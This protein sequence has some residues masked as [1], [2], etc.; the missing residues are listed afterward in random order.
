MIFEKIVFHNIDEIYQHKYIEGVLLERIPESVALGLSR[1]GQ[2]MMICPSGSEIRFVSTSYPVR[3]TLSV[4]KIAEQLGEG[5]VTDAHIFFGVFHSRQRFVIKKR[6]TVLE[7]N[8]P[9]NFRKMAERVT[10]NEPFSYNVCRIRFWGTSMGAP[11]RFHNIESAGKIRPPAPRETPNLRYLAYGS[12]LTQGAYATGP[13]LCYA[14]QVGARLGADVIN[15]GSSCSAF[16]EPELADYIAGRNDW[17]FATLALSVNMVQLFSPGEF[18]A[19]VSYMI[20]TVAKS[21]KRRPVFFITIKPYYGDYVKSEKPCLY[22]NLLRKAVHASPHK[23]VYLIEGP[24][25]MPDV[26]GG[27]CPDMVHLGDYGMIQIGEKLA[28]KTRPV[29]KAYGLLD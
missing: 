20:D 24:E 9:P 27:L 13:H 22:R 4:D 15:L 2:M 16:C 11:I 8:M 18:S 25:L 7:I 19:R 3:I 14:N 10:K 26:A 6:K 29:L 28:E 23:N 12:S 21:N 1:A 17:D 5:I